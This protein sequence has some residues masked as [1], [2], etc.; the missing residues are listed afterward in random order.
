M[1]QSLQVLSAFVQGLGLVS[2]PSMA[3]LNLLGLQLQRV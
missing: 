3:V 2:E 1:S